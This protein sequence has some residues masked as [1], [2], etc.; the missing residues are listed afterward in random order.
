MAVSTSHMFLLQ[1]EEQEIMLLRAIKTPTSAST[2]QISN[3]R[4]AQV[5]SHR[6][7]VIVFRCSLLIN[8]MNASS[9][10]KKTGKAKKMCKPGMILK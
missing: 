4:I 2:K 7:L 3:C 10:C 5:V 8:A 6:I 9:W 1:E